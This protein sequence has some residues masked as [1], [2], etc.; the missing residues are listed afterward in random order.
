MKTASDP[1]KKGR[2]LRD[3]GGKTGK[4]TKCDQSVSARVCQSVERERFLKMVLD[5]AGL[6][7]CWGWVGCRN[8]AGYPRF[9]FNGHLGYAHRFSYEEWIG[10]IPKGYDLHHKCENSWCVNPQHLEPLISGVHRRNHN[11]QHEFCVRGHLL[12]SDN[13]ICDSRKKD[14]GTRCRECRRLHHWCVR[15]GL[16]MTSFTPEELAVLVGPRQRRVHHKPQA[17]AC[18]SSPLFV[19][20]DAAPDSPERIASNRLG[21]AAKCSPFF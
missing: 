10:P 21:L 5:L 3:G 7:A 9:R 17:A 12:T 14:D 19:A 15:H 6:D 4:R 8:K 16:R 11:P 13:R 1:K 2:R 18:S 20:T